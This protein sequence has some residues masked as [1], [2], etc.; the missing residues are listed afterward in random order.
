MAVQSPARIA[1]AIAATLAVLGFAAPAGS[2]LA[3]AAITRWACMP[4]PS[5]WPPERPSRTWNCP[6]T[7]TC[8]S[9]PPRPA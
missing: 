6:G 7:P 4:R 1:T 5:R 3:A 2:P 9:L 8:T